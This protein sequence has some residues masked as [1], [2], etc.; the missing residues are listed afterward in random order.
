MTMKTYR[1]FKTLSLLLMLALVSPAISAAPVTAPTEADAARAT[2]LKNRLEEIR[3]ID[4][5]NLSKTEKK[6][7]RKEVQ[8]IKKEMAAISGGVYLSVGAI[9]L[10]VLLI[11]L[12]A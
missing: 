9:V 4:K 10:I 5:H 6:A 12:L 7:L 8:A 1:L 3:D 2:T 11:L